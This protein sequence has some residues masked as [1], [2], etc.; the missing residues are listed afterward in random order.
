MLIETRKNTGKLSPEKSRGK[1]G[2]EEGL[3]KE[4]DRARMYVPT[5]N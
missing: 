3:R 4:E 2:V 1:K 5:E